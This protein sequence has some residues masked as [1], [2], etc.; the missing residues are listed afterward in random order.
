MKSGWR[1]ECPKMS[2]EVFDWCVTMMQW[3][4][5]CGIERKEFGNIH[6][7]QDNDISKDGGWFCIECNKEPIDDLMARILEDKSGNDDMLLM[8]V[9]ARED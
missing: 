8:P 4:N 2:K 6:I 7:E 3:A 9:S 1:F 5:L